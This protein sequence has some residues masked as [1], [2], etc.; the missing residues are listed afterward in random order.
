MSSRAP[1]GGRGEP[2]AEPA[3]TVPELLTRQL[4]AA[5]TELQVLRAAC[6]VLAVVTA[7]VSGRGLG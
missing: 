5:R 6:A 1:A 4:R 2:A 7:Y 3:I